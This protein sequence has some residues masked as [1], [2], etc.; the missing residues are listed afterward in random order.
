ME[1]L[2]QVD[3]KDC[4]E[5]LLELRGRYGEGNP[6]FI[7]RD[8]VPA[9]AKLDQ[10]G[11]SFLQEHGWCKMERITKYMADENGVPRQLDLTALH[12]LDPALKF[13][14]GCKVTVE[15]HT[16]TKVTIEPE[17]EPVW[18]ANKRYRNF[19]RTERG[20]G[21]VTSSPEGLASNIRGHISA[22]QHGGITRAEWK[23]RQI[24]LM[25]AL[26]YRYD[27]IA[28]PLR[29][30]AEDYRDLPFRGRRKHD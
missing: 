19:A 13:L 25:Y 29:H 21:I 30:E 18:K 5:V 17:P 28:E 26:L 27:E 7:R 16:D 15:Q 1:E 20:F 4:V 24:W 2:S 3:K 9:F 22:L 14:E 8:K 6:I 23:S 11:C 10:D 12:L